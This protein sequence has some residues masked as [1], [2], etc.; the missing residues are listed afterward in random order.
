[1]NQQYYSLYDCFCYVRS[2][3]AGDD[4]L[5]AAV[6]C[7]IL[8]V[9]FIIGVTFISWYIW[10][11]GKCRRTN[12]LESVESPPDDSIHPPPPS[13]SQPPISPIPQIPDEHQGPTVTQQVTGVSGGRRVPQRMP[14]NSFS[15][16][17][18]ETTCTMTNAEDP[19]VLDTTTSTYLHP[20]NYSY[21]VREDERYN[22]NILYAHYGESNM[23]TSTVLSV[24]CKSPYKWAWT[25]DR[26][27]IVYRKS[28]NYSA[29]LITA[30]L[31]T[32]LH[33]ST[34]KFTFSSYIICRV[35]NYLFWRC[36]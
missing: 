19:S 8:V 15:R 4:S 24:C 1:M 13:I 32:F 35:L 22:N 10:K 33:K 16:L 31:G 14:G 18:V 2:L 34:Y 20:L 6:T 23:Y 5:I 11:Q 17:S 28:S 25:P 36:N 27:V 9:L 26:M 21:E 3:R 30:P 29:T 7:T 12:T